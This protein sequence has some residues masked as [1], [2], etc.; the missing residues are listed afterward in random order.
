MIIRQLI[1]N[2]N[3]NV[4]RI[5]KVKAVPCKAAPLCDILSENAWNGRRC[6]LLGGG[7]SLM[8][9]DYQRLDK[10]L[11]IGIN[12]TF[13]VYKSTINYSMDETFYTRLTDRTAD[14]YITVEH[15]KKW[16]DYQGIKLFLRQSEKQAFDKFVYYIPA[17]HRKVFSNSIKLGIYGG[18]NSGFGALMLAITFGC[19]EIYLLG[20]DFKVKQTKTKNIKTH[21]HNG[22]RDESQK[23]M[24][25]K[26]ESFIREFEEFE[27]PIRERGIKVINLNPESNLTCFPTA[28][29][30][31]ILGK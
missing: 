16:K 6:F 4:T 1:N 12:K 21:W 26:F 3:S 9:F 10:E 7:P 31:D 28:C 2:K 15:K 19:K 11:T 8:G 22:Y 5:A 18:N 23:R 27:G 24:N 14:K 25:Q 30:D 29:I 20:Y 13:L 17:V